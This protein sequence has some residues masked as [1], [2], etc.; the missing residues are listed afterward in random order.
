MGFST[1]EIFGQLSA[2]EQKGYAMGFSNGIMT[3]GILGADLKKVEMLH[4]CTDRMDSKQIASIIDKY[5][6]EHP[7][8]WHHI[9]AASSFS[10]LVD[11][12]PDLKKE[13][14]APTTVH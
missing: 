5:I 11:V 2:D 9:L 12:C 3:S 1:R 10:A 14:A 7:E 6:K 8:S 4:R 13:L